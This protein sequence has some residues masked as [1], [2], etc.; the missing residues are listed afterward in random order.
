MEKTFRFITAIALLAAMCLTACNKVEPTEDPIDEPGTEVTQGW[1]VAISATM[2][3]DASTKALAEDPGT[4]NLIATFETTDNIYV[5]N[6]T[7]KVVDANPL[8][9]DKNGASAVLTGTLAG[10]Y[11]KDDELVLCYNSNNSGTFVYNSGQKGTISTVKDYAKAEIS[12]TAA[13]AASKSITGTANFV[14]MQSIFSFNFTDGS[15]TVPVKA[16]QVS[17]DGSKLVS[18]YGVR[19]N[20]LNPNPYSDYGQTSI[21]TDDP[22]S[23]TVYVALRNDNE[24]DDTYHFMVNDGAGHLYKGEKAAPAGK[25]VNGKHYSSTV[26]LTPV[27]LPAVKLTASGTPVGP[28]AAWDE[29]LV[30][31]G[32]SNLTFGYANYGDLT[33]S[34]NSNGSWFEW[35]T[36]DSSGGDRTV[37]LY[38]ATITEPDGGKIPLENQDG[39]FTLILSGDNSIT[40]T[41]SPAIAFNGSAIHFQGNGTLTITAATTEVD[42]SV[43]GI[44]GSDTTPSPTAASGYVLTVS[45]G[46]DNGDGT[47]TWVYTV[48]STTSGSAGI[49]GGATQEWVQLWADGPKWAK[50]NVG[51]TI[52]TYAGVTAYTNP[53]VVGGYYSYR[54]RYDSQADSQGTTDTAT[55]VW[56]S[57]WQT[58]TKDQEQALLDKCTW[59]YVDGTEGNQFEAGCTLSGWKVSGKEAGYTGNSIFLPYAGIRDQNAISREDVGSRGVYWSSTAGG[60]GAYYLN[61]GSGQSIRHA[62]Q[63]H[64]CSVRAIYVGAE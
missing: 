56:G 29:S 6:A 44:K 17:T 25:I 43:K 7:K 5:Y 38:G 47:S 13:D 19:Q 15:V 9:P 50:F 10:D 54:G 30:K 42:H 28:N 1:T 14:N 3:S 46:V 62:N 4:H 26:T 45:E 61:L 40:T 53:D 35:L 21:V 48:R 39:G 37:T 16:L 58:P 52:T 27:A 22:I 49:T 60:S 55:Y 51:S 36:Y 64:G 24:A 33:I 20:D 59:E 8:H 12:I 34:G 32:W 31:L 57:N 23:G 63:P 41:G 18:Q 11:D 2:G